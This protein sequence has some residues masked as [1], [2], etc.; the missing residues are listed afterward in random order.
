MV[1]GALMGIGPQS[2]QAR[3]AATK[4]MIVDSQIHIWKPD[5]VDRPWVKGSNAQLPEPMT[6][7]RLL[8]IMDEAGVDRVIVVPPSLEGI[9][10]DYGQEA[11]RQYPSRFATMSRVNLNESA[12]KNRVILMRTEPYLL[13]ARFYFQPSIAHWLLDGTADW[14]WGL[15]ESI[16]L[17]VMFLTIKQTPIF[18]KIAERHPQL[19]LIV[20]H[21]GV[22]MESVKDGS[23][24]ERI[25]EAVALA[26]YPNVSVKL[27]SSPLYSIQSYPWRDMD[28][29]I[30]HL[31][32]AYGPQRCHWGTDLTNSF[33]RGSMKQRI[34]HFT[35]ELRFL[36][37]DDKD[38]IMGRSIM[39]KLS[40][41]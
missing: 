25:S 12:E 18:A 30:R 33:N 21:L 16:K 24:T 28:D 27:S 37:E 40:W 14:F 41:I 15:A 10:F 19:P 20:D 36:S 31:F 8:P 1:G 29:H 23:V 32:D 39:E 2:V 34:E 22:T 17:P 13:G 9:R 6:V 35:Q 11:A 3:S 7:E 26:K 38:W 5:T 4:R